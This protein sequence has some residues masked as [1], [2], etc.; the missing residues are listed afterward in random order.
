MNHDSQSKREYDELPLLSPLSPDLHLWQFFSPAVKLLWVNLYCEKS[1]EDKF[2][3]LISL[4]VTFL[5]SNDREIK[6]NCQYS[7]LSYAHPHHPQH[8]HHHCCCCCCCRQ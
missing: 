1:Y 6:S 8:Q 7:F 3:F 4:P 2:L 5:L